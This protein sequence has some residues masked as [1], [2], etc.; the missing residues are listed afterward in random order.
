MAADTDNLIKE[1]LDL[2]DQV[3]V[4]AEQQLAWFGHSTPLEGEVEELNKLAQKRQALMQAI[5][6]KIAILQATGVNGNGE[7]SAL[8][9]RIM[10]IDDQVQEKAQAWM[11]ELKGK[12]NQGGTARQ[13]NRAYGG[14]RPVMGAAFFDGKR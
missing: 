4:L 14:D 12:L 13:A 2:F 11:H 5:D 1:L 6:V 8:V 3:L 7:L 10:N 9:Q